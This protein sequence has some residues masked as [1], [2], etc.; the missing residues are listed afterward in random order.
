MA[1]FSR[2]FTVLLVRKPSRKLQ[3]A[4]RTIAWR[5]TDDASSQYRKLCG[6]S[7]G[8]MSC[9]PA[10]KPLNWNFLVCQRLLHRQTDTNTPEGFSYGIQRSSLPS[11]AK[12]SQLLVCIIK[13]GE[14]REEVYIQ[15]VSYLHRSWQGWWGGGVCLCVTEWLNYL[16]LNDGDDR[17]EYL[18]VRIR[19]K[20]NKMGVCY[21]QPSW[22]KEVDQMFYKHLG[23]VFWET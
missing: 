14:Y 13:Q 1:F 17:V 6:K 8:N 20:A 7:S 2:I 4:W 15:P 23:E 12:Q 22:N 19:G 10:G 18:R 3:P 11:N 21:R 9:H 5:V 16:E